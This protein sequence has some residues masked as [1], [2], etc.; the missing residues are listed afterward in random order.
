MFVSFFKRQ[1][2]PEV[3]FQTDFFQISYEQNQIQN[4]EPNQTRQ[5][6]LENDPLDFDLKDLKF[7]PTELKFLVSEKWLFLESK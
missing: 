2:D 7:T 6:E 3:Q 1:K 5:L 4:V